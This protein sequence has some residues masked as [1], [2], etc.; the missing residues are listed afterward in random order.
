LASAGHKK[1][2]KYFSEA[3]LQKIVIGTA[4]YRIIVRRKSY[5]AKAEDT[6]QL[7]WAFFATATRAMGGANISDDEENGSYDPAALTSPQASGA[8]F[9]IV[10]TIFVSNPAS[11]TENR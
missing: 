7:R 2:A 4:R 8:V 1:T 3:V 10:D 5:R 9:R 11:K 6:R